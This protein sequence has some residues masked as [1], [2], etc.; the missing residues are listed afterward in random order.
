MIDVPALRQLH[1]VGRPV[2]TWSRLFCCIIGFGAL[3]V[4]GSAVAW[5]ATLQERLENA[6]VVREFD[7]EGAHVRQFEVAQ[8]LVVL[9][10]WKR[11]STVIV[12][13]DLN[14]AERFRFGLRNA[15][16]RRLGPVEVSEDGTT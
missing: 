2:F 9:Q 12:A 10:L 16:N 8:D 4:F 13:Y 15:P 6:T 14:G 11:D 1:G 7:A 5:G 3:V